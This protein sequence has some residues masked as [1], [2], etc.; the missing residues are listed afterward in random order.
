MRGQD[1]PTSLAV[2]GTTSTTQIP[3]K[4][5]DIVSGKAVLLHHPVQLMLRPIRR[6]RTTLQLIQGRSQAPTTRTVGE[7]LT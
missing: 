2:S 4:V 1:R 7:S 3:F 6:D 5:L